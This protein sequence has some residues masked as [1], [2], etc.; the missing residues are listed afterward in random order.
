M[1]ARTARSRAALLEGPIGPTLA[2]LAV[3][4]IA[5]MAIQS[6]MSIVEA[7]YLGRLGT[8][9]LAA[10]ALVFPILML[11]NM[12]SA[13]AVGGAVSGATANATGAGD[14]ARA[15]TIL[16]AALLIA[17]CCGLAMAALFYFAGPTF[18]RL[19]G[20]EGDVLAA[21][22]AYSDRLM[23]ALVL[24]WLF[25]M[26]AG[27]MRGAG[28]MLRPAMLQALV[29]ASHFGLSWLLILRLDLGIAGAAWAMG[30]AYAAGLAAVA[31]LF[32]GGGAAVA[33]RPGPVPRSLVMPLLRIGSLA[34]FQA[35]MTIV[36]ALTVTALVGRLG[37]VWLAGYGIA[38]RL[39]FLMIPIIFG[40]GSAMIAMVGAN[41]G[42]GR[43]DRAQAV[44]WRGS[45]A[46]ALIVG[47]IGVASAL[48]PVFW[49]SLY[50]ADA[51]VIEACA[52]YMRRVAPFYAFF[53]L[54][55]SLYFAAQAMQ[56]MGVP[57]IAS[58]SRFAIIAGGGG[59]LLA[60]G[61]AEPDAVFICV[62]LGMA[63]YGVI[64]AAGLRWVSWR[65]RPARRPA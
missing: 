60:A 49:A 47:A 2:R 57:V 53:G 24:I 32:A 21:A 50:T 55:L 18:Y 17:L 10:V 37:P 41:R 48:F 30:G 40:I 35:V 59:A 9:E 54:G 29:A 15:E 13:G 5:A 28:D 12:L 65:P 22:L 1:N 38:A 20:G 23:P 6:S 52:A 26:A 25:N 14:E 51:A 33:F 7:W 16:R 3:P 39:E 64:V 45:G 56:T 11:A 44:A 62:A 63:A 46:A 42:A 43:M 36:T 58:L 8:V 4:G 31:L 19:L 27:V 61:R 34:G